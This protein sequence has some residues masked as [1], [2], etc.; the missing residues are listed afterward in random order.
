MFKK[1][2][3]DI[4]VI[5]QRKHSRQTD[6]PTAPSKC[7]ACSTKNIQH[8]QGNWEIMARQPRV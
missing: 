8:E 7:V 4:T 5:K 3:K 6:G 1:F 2:N